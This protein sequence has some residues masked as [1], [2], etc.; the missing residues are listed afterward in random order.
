MRVPWVPREAIERKAHKVIYEYGKMVG[1]NVAPPIPVEHIIEG[2]LG[3]RLCF[4]DLEEKFGQKGI[5]G[6]LILD[7]GRVVI[8]TQLAESGP[9]GRYCFTCSHEVGHWILHR[10]LIK[11]AAKRSGDQSAIICRLSDARKSHEWQADYFAACL[12]MPRKHVFEAFKTVCGERPLV[13]ENEDSKLGGTWVA[14]DP[15]VS[16]WHYIAQLVCNAGGF[17]NV[18]KEAMAI[19]MLELGLIVNT[20]EAKIGWGV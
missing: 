6:V 3:L 13:L 19:R 1:R 14:V 16:N 11:K 17:D 7:E 15:C 20:T 5:L 8:N 10:H 4:E 9:E 18:S 2:F 12:L